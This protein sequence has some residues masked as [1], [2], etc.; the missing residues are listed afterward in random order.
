MSGAWVGE[1]CSGIVEVA[2]D[3]N[4]TRRVDW[5][6]MSDIGRREERLRVPEVER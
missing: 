1:V 4:C 3:T 6:G 2:V 5:G